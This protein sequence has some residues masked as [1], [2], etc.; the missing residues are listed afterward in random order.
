MRQLRQTLQLCLSSNLSVRECSRVLG[1]GKTTV[2]SIISHARAAGLDWTLAQSLD[3]AQLK[4]RLYPP[5]VGRC[6][7]HLEPDYT[8]I[9]QELKRCG[10][11]LQLLWE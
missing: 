4:A 8:H 2:S 7:S 5:A 11:T 9:H 10:V 3:D 6:S 1:I